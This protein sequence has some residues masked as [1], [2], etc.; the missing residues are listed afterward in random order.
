MIGEVT[1][2]AS[3]QSEGISQ[4][5][6]AVGQLDQMTQQNAALVEEATAAAQNLQEQALK[7]QQA[8]SFFQTE[9]GATTVLSLSPDTPAPRL[10]KRPLH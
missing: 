6:A 4:V 5:N 9:D 2:A 3:E 1:A 7:L 10:G 8:I